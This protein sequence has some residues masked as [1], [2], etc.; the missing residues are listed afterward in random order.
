M[1]TYQNPVYPNYFADP[2]V[3]RHDGKYFAVGTGP[4]ELPPESDEVRMGNSVAAGDDR[5][6]PVLY[7]ENFVEWKFAGS[8]LR[9]TRSTAGGDFWAPEVA[10]ENGKFYLYYSV[11]TEGLKHQLRVATSQSPLGPYEDAGALMTDPANCPFAIDAHPFRD[12]DGQ[13]YMFYA[14]DFLDFGNGLRAGTA[15][16]V[17]RL[18]GMTRLAGEET[19]VLRSRHDWHLFKAGRAMYGKILDWH[20]LE[21]PCVCKRDGSYYCFFSGGCYENSSYGVDYAVADSVRGPYSDVGSE[22]GARILRTVPGRLIG[23]GHHSIVRGPDNETDYIAYHAWDPGMTAR[24]MCLDKLIWTS[25]G[26]RSEGPTWTPQRVV[27]H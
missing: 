1:L 22:G 4:I 10:C 7:S 5:A 13:W 14:R 3:W 26:P 19:T 12:D 6:F 8:A 11:S 9:V 21:G 16:V 15:L 17:D 20:T 2:F 25:D 23:P 24:R 18:A 27:H